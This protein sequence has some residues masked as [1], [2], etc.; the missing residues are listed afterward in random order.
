MKTID[1]KIV[2]QRWLQVIKE[3]TRL[4][5]VTVRS[6]LWSTLIWC[7]GLPLIFS[8]F[9]LISVSLGWVSKDWRSSLLAGI[10]VFPLLYLFL[11]QGR[12]LARFLGQFF[13]KGG[14]LGVLDEAETEGLW[15]ER[16]IEKWHKEL[17][18]FRISEWKRILLHFEADLERLSSRVTYLTFLTGALFFLLFKGWNL[19]DSSDELFNQFVR[20]D[21]V[22]SWVAALIM[23]WN[24]SLIL[25]AFLVLVYL[26]GVQNSNYLRRYLYCLKVITHEQNKSK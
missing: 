3:S 24:D 26:A 16:Q 4:D 15:R 10:V 2:Y 18:E 9:L 11:G 21:G 13:S 14:T 5:R 12:L 19:G 17:P 1:E 8:I 20:P 6:H 7:V 23:E 25:L 22:T